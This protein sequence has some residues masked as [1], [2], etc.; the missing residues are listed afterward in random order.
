MCIVVVAVSKCMVSWLP[1]SYQAIAVIVDV[2]VAVDV[3]TCIVDCCVPHA[4]AAA[5]AILVVA[6]A[7]VL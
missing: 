6:S 2:V 4:A 1:F 7:A 3:E 5:V